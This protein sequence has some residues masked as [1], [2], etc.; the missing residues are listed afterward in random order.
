M[1]ESDSLHNRLAGILCCWSSGHPAQAPGPNP[2]QVVCCRNVHCIQFSKSTIDS[3]HG[4]THNCTRR[5]NFVGVHTTPIPLFGNLPNFGGDPVQSH[6]VRGRNLYTRKRILPR[7]KAHVNL[8]LPAPRGALS[9]A[10]CRAQLT[11][12][13]ERRA[14]APF[15]Q[16]RRSI[17]N[18]SPHV[19]RKIA[20]TFGTLFAP[21]AGPCAP[22][23][24]SPAIRIF[25]QPRIK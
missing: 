1:S 12:R 16:S 7:F 3:F 8:F 19:N 18:G 20:I 13:Q 14:S 11:A 21:G 23:R 24:S 5:A 10:R 6:P 17:S 15:L 25:P 22:R 4:E 9:D 2:S